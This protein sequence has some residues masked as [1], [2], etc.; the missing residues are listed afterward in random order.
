MS[1][2]VVPFYD[3]TVYFRNKYDI[4][5]QSLPSLANLSYLRIMTVIYESFTEDMLFSKQR[6]DFWAA[7]NEES[8]V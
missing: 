4:I 6:H 5:S 2:Q 8:L 7:R 3:I 1:T